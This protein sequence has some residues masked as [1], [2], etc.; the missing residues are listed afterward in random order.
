MP[1]HIEIDGQGW[2]HDRISFLRHLPEGM[3]SHSIS[4]QGLWSLVTV[5]GLVLLS[6]S[7]I[8]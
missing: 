5:N 6:V 1:S 7:F 8:D 4:P 2:N 3:G